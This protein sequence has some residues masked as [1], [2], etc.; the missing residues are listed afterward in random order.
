M[1]GF[2][3]L[4]TMLPLLLTAVNEGKLTLD[5]LVARLHTNP[6]HIFSLPDQMDTYVEID[7][8]EEWVIPEKPLF[9]KGYIDRS[10]SQRVDV[11]V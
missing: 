2:P 11:C 5:D 6:K 7:M 8:D 1:P 9:S 10:Y 4:E 3:G